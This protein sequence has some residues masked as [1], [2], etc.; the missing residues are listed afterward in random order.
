MATAWITEF[1][2]I[3]TV[4]PGKDIQAGELPE[5]QTTKVTY[6]TSTQHTFHA[7]AR[8]F[9]IRTDATAHIL[10]AANPTADDADTPVDAFVAEYFGINESGLVLAIYDGTS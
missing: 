6:T 2:K 7:D 4:S 8:C 5:L 3:G 9:R 1:S 10:V